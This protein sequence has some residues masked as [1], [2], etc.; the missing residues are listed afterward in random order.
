MEGNYEKYISNNTNDE[1]KSKLNYIRILLSRL[2]N[3]II[4]DD[5]NRVRKNL[6][7]I[8]KKQKLTKIQKEKFFNHL[9]ELANALNKK[10]KEYKYSDH[11]DLDYFGIKDIQDLFTNIDDA[12]YY[13]PKLAKSS[14]KNNF[15]YYEIRGDRDKNISVKQYLT[16][17]IP[18]LAK[19]TD[20]KKNNN[21]EQKNSVKYGRKFHVCY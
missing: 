13:K 5:R 15:P 18:Q 7:E 20:E 4:K 6:Y 17:I 3:I 9:I 16:M 2:V 19:L 1:I 14:F 12:D 8:E 11:D 21:N 10:K